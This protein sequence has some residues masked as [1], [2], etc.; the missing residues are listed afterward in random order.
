MKN[1]LR[2]QLF[3][4]VLVLSANLNCTLAATKTMTESNNCKSDCIDK[5]KNFCPTG[6]KS[7]GYCCEEEATCPLTTEC[8][9]EALGAK[10]TVLQRWA[11]PNENNCGGDWQFQLE[12]DETKQAIESLVLDVGGKTDNF[13]KPDSCGYLIEGPPQAKA[14]DELHFKVWKKSNA[15]LYLDE[16]LT[17]DGKTTVQRKLSSGKTYKAIYP[18]KVWL[19]A[20]ATS[21][22]R[23]GKFLVQFWYKEVEEVIVET[24]VDNGSSTDDKGETDE[25]TT[26]TDPTDGENTSGGSTEDGGTTEEDNGIVIVVDDEK[27]KEDN[28][29]G[30]ST[31]SGSENNSGDNGSDQGTGETGGDTGSGTNTG[32]GG[33]GTVIDVEAGTPDPKEPGL[34]EDDK[35]GS[36][37]DDVTKIVLIV[38]FV[39]V[40]VIAGIFAV[41]VCLIKRAQKKKEGIRSSKLNQNES[42]A[43][44]EKPSPFKEMTPRGEKETPNPENGA[45]DP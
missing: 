13:L 42:E 14:G 31:D 32:S 3:W 45:E 44:I 12:R 17:Y 36:S 6:S 4:A 9:Y 24:P 23:H 29:D 18:N 22:W 7:K 34:A 43:G 41:F 30:G 10:N 1:V 2:R 5:G 8:S 27:E 39:I 11:C 28:T 37:K 20:T 19:T 35:T 16:G 15:N 26:V 38:V 21:S 33:G 25:E 40:A